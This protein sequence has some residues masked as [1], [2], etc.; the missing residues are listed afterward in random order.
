MQCCHR[1]T[2]WT[3]NSISGAFCCHRPT[4]WTH[5]STRGRVSTQSSKIPLVSKSLIITTLLKILGANRAEDY[6]Q[7]AVNQAF[8]DQR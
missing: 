7:N 3:H 1:P 6:L 4:L 2:L 8:S 5:N